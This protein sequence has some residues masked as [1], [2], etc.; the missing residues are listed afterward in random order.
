MPALGDLHVGAGMVTCISTHGHLRIEVTSGYQPF[1]PSS[2]QIPGD[3]PSETAPPASV[4]ELMLVT[5]GM[6]SDMSGHLLS[7][8]SPSAPASHL[9]APTLRPGG[10]L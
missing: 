4:R 3:G 2:Q 9:R 1:L 5:A 7:Q 6:C 8:R 10:L